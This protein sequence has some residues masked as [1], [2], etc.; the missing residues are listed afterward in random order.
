MSDTS[1]SIVPCKVD[2]QNRLIKAQQV[3]EWLTSLHVVKP[4]KTDCI[5][6]K[7]LGYSI[8]SGAA[9]MTDYPEELPYSL[10]VNGLQVITDRTVFD[11]GEDGLD[12]FICP[13]CNE[14]IISLE[15]TL[16]D[17]H[18]NGNAMLSCPTCHSSSSLNEYIIEP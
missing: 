11:A 2:Y 16:E 12:C 5:L 8:G 18:V 10:K 4:V 3:T 1:I 15:W 17:Y 13:K 7:E 6:S 14:D 9:I